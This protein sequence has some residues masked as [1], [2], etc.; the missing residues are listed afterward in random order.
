MIMIIMV[1]MI[2][3]RGCWRGGEEENKQGCCS[4]LEQKGQSS[5]NAFNRIT[6]SHNFTITR[7]YIAAVPKNY[8]KPRFVESLRAVLTKVEIFVLNCLKCY[9]CY[10]F[11]D[12]GRNICTQLLQVLYHCYNFAGQG[13]NICTASN[14]TTVLTQEGLV[15]FE[16]KV[17]GYPTPLLRL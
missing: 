3:S 17:V 11:A 5:P 2:P 8:R 6:L 14:I 1:V 15:S 12:Q 7:N 16:C 9:H 13:R 4:Y 10:H